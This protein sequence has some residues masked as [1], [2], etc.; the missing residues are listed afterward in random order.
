MTAA[1]RGQGYSGR[2]RFKLVVVGFVS[3][4]G[5]L[6]LF[7]LLIVVLPMIALAVLVTQVTTQSGNGKADAR[8]ASGLRTSLAIYERDTGAAEQAARRIGGS[9]AL[10]NALRSGDR[11]Q[12][13]SA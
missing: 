11:S 7:F 10:A 13:Q 9:V 8:L 1:S 2:C 12:V 4:R 5:R 6:T 3:F